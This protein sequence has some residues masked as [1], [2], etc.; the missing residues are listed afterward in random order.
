MEL[1]LDT[2]TGLFI[3]ALAVGI[4]LIIDPDSFNDE[5]HDTNN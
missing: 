5:L 3:Y 2:K 4:N 1:S